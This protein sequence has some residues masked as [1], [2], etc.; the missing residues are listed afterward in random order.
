MYLQQQN[1]KLC[2]VPLAV[3]MISVLDDFLYKLHKPI[4]GQLLDL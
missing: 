3:N 1:P 4:F 2:K